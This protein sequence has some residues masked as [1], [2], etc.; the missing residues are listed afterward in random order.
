MGSFS[1]LAIAREIARLVREQQ[2]GHPDPLLG[3]QLRADLEK[4]YGPLSADELRQPCLIAIDQA[5]TAHTRSE[6]ELY[7]TIYIGE[8][9]SP[10]IKRDLVDRKRRKSGSPAC[11][12]GNMETAARER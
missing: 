2:A 8:Y 11:D 6:D 9:L 1:P 3:P 4:R 12:E 5:K 10:P 7:A